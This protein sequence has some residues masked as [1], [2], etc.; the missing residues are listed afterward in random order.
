MLSGVQGCAWSWVMQVQ[1]SVPLALFGGWRKPA[2][3]QSR[4]YAP[5]AILGAGSIFGSYLSVR[6]FG[7]RA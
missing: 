2:G 4:Q 1:G 7:F 6:G 3:P 5:D